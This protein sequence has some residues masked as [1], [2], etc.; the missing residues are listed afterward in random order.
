MRLT[1]LFTRSSAPELI[2]RDNVGAAEAIS[3]LMMSDKIGPAFLV[4]LSVAFGSYGV[5]ELVRAYRAEGLEQWREKALVG[6]GGVL[7]GALLLVAL[8]TSIG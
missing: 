7:L 8:R 5:R 2:G 1:T 4:L 3:R 6:A